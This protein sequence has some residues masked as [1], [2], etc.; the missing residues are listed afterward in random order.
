MNE[1][2]KYLVD[3]LVAAKQELANLKRVYK[4][5][6]IE[7]T[8]PELVDYRDLLIKYN[9]LESTTPELV[10]A[11]QELANLNFVE[12]LPAI[13]RRI[14]D[15]DLS[16]LNNYEEMCASALNAQSVWKNKKIS[17]QLS[18]ALSRFIEQKSIINNLHNKHKELK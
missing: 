11:K 4:A 9:S 18:D 10:A 15:Y 3:E 7:S 5:E 2:I 14:E 17:I 16:D 12:D 1:C 8:T 13:L 6:A